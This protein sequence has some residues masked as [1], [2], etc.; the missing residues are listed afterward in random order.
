MN[1]KKEQVVCGCFNVTVGDLKKS[2]E[3]E[4]NLL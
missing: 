2:I 3:N 4:Q 1:F